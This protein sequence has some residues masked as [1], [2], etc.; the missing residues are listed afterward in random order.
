MAEE[1][2][3]EPAVAAPAPVA[4]EPTEPQLE[5]AAAPSN[6]LPDEVLRIP[7]MQALMAGA[8]PALSASIKTLEKRE[9]GKILAKNGPALQS[10]G[11]GLYRSLSG[12]QGV[13]FNQLFISGEQ[14]QQADKAG[15]LAQIAPTFDSVNDTVARSGAEN[16]VLNAGAPPAAFATPP[17]PE[18]PQTA[19]GLLPGPPASAQTSLAK[20]RS[21]NLQEGSPTSGRAGQGRLLNNLLK[22][23]I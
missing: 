3:I 23:A 5:E 1:V 2:V 7:A 12:E 17:P 16:P 9:E 19:S 11:I 6:E 14:L 15:Q 20:A 22:P 10:A 21:K 18:P 8:P 4:I 13:I